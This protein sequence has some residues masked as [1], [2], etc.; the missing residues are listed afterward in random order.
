MNSVKV[1]LGDKEVEVSSEVS[2]EVISEVLG[3]SDWLMV[4]V[5]VPWSKKDVISLMEVGA[6]EDSNNSV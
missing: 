2:S 3:S 1:T 4:E 6:V 5:K